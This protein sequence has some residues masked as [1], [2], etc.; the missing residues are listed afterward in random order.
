MTIRRASLALVCCLLLS[1]PAWA[2][3]AREQEKLQG[4][5]GFT[6]LTEG[7]RKGQEKDIE[8][9]LVFKGNTVTFT[10]KGKSLQGTYVVDPGQKPRTMDITYEKDGEKL[11][12]PMIYE[13][14]GDTLKFCHFEGSSQ[15]GR[16]KELVASEKTVLAVLKREKK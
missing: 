8:L 2:V 9:K 7:G 14:E 10:G 13:L 1:T 12:V 11:T 5:W 3:D 6:E 15:K 4:T 16:P